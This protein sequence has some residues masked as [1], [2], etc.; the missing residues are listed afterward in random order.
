MAI[1]LSAYR[2]YRRGLLGRAYGPRYYGRGRGWRGYRR[3]WH[4]M[5]APPV[6]PLGPVPSAGIAWAQQALAQIFGPV[7]PQDGILGPE[8]RGFVARF[9]AQQG[10]SPTG[11]L[12]DVTMAT[13]QDATAPPP[14]MP[15]P[16]PEPPPPI[17]GAPP[18]PTFV[19]P[20]GPP[21][22]IPAPP[23]HQR[24]DRPLPPG[25]PGSSPRRRA[26]SVAIARYRP[27]RR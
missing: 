4:W 9:Q 11:D 18:P 23:R 8:T 12:D 19:P 1:R 13:L 10:L 7:V 20:P 27:V 21:G 22:V 2:G 25:P 6:V 16:L 5:H 3:R 14:V 17:F 24:R 15:P 26:I